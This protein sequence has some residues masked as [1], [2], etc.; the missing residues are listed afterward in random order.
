[1]LILMWCVF[2]LAEQSKKTILLTKEYRNMPPTIICIVSYNVQFVTGCE[3][4]DEH[5]PKRRL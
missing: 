2:F 1:M 3:T 5:K 4:E